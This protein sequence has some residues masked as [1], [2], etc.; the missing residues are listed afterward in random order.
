[1]DIQIGGKY[2]I[3]K[4]QKEQV[5]IIDDIYNIDN[6]V[7]YSFTYGNFGFHEGS[8]TAN[9]IRELTDIE[10]QNQKQFWL[11]PQQFYQSFPNY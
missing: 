6:T 5:A 9:Q 7:Y 10:K 8:C 3:V 1:M 4:H 2:I 11:L